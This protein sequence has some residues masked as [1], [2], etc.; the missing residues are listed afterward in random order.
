MQFLQKIVGQVQT[1]DKIAEKFDDY[2]NEQQSLRN[3]VFSRVHFNRSD[4]TSI[5]R[6]IETFAVYGT[7]SNIVSLNQ[8][9]MKDESERDAALLRSL[10]WIEDI[11]QIYHYGDLNFHP[12]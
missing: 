9:V 5:A 8:Q 11:S 7:V 3:A 6:N 12:I 10:Q 1:L 2:R 4:L